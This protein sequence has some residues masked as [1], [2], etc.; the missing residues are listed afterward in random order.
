MRI[1]TLPKRFTGSDPREQIKKDFPPLSSNMETTIGG[2]ITKSF[3]I[4]YFED[5]VS[6]FENWFEDRD[7]TNINSIEIKFDSNINEDEE[8]YR[9]ELDLFI[10]AKNKKGEILLEI[11]L[12][13]DNKY[14]ISSLRDFLSYCLKDVYE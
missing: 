5:I 10:N 1:S 7:D 11:Y 4:S 3:S 13:M 6:H 12:N 8:R 9:K 14:Q 2:R